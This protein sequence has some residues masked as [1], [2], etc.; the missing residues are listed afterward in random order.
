MNHVVQNYK[1]TIR[2]ILYFPRSSLALVPEAGYSNFAGARRAHIQHVDCRCRQG[3]RRRERVR[4][5]LA[6]GQARRQAQC[7]GGWVGSVG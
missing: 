3:E 6:H 2:V 7:A 5:L 4:V 1:F